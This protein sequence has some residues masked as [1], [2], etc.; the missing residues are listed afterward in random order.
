MPKY[1]SFKSKHI[2]CFFANISLFYVIFLEKSGKKKKILILLIS[3]FYT[4][5]NNHHF[6]STIEYV[7]ILCIFT[8]KGRFSS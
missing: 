8:N 3:D 6:V 2:C 4:E 1:I 7:E 5:C